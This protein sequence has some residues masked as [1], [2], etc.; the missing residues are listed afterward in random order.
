METTK[1]RI[2][3]QLDTLSPEELQAIHQLIETFKGEAPSAALAE[4]A[5]GRVRAALSD[6]PGALADTIHEEREDRVR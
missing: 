4:Q 5:A 3:R 2:V 1:E 6:L